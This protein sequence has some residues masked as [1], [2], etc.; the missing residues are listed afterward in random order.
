MGSKTIYVAGIFHLI[1]L[2]I[3]KQIKSY[4]EISTSFSLNTKIIEKI[5]YDYDE[6]IDAFIEVKNLITSQMIDEEI[7]DTIIFK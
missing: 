7:G 1:T 3:V 2:V 6:L 5:Q 4:N